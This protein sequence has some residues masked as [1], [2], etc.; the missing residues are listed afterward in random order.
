MKEKQELEEKAEN[1][2][3]VSEMKIGADGQLVPVE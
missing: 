3:R 2:R 1:E